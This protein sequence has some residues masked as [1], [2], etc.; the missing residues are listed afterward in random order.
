MRIV[1][2]MAGYARNPMNAQVKDTESTGKHRDHRETPDCSRRVGR[3]SMNF[4]LRSLFLRHDVEKE[5]AARG[6]QVKCGLCSCTKQTRALPSGNAR[7][8]SFRIRRYSVM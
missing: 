8:R 1:F 6:V 4:A 3:S 7:V 2:S 5:I